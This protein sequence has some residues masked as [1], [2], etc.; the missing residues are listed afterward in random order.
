MGL[1]Y[2][3]TSHNINIAG[4]IC[5][6]NVL[7]CQSLTKAHWHT[8]WVVCF[9][10]GYRMT[11]PKVSAELVIQRPDTLFV[12]MNTCVKSASN[13]GILKLN[14]SQ[15]MICHLCIIV[16]IHYNVI[17]VQPLLRANCVKSII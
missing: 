14:L 3:G 10:I 11:V 9:I 13:G 15:K 16:M 1:L 5:N 6:I 7:S 8:V 12:S 17:H 2:I 4:Y